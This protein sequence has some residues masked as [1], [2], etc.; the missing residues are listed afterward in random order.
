MSLRTASAIGLFWLLVGFAYMMSF[1]AD[2][3]R[4]GTKFKLSVG[5]V[6]LFETV[7]LS[8]A[9][10][11]FALHALLRGPITRRAFFP[12]ATIFIGGMLIWQPAIAVIDTTITSL[13]F[14][15]PLDTV[16]E[17]ALAIR[18]TMFFFNA[19][20]Y[21]VVFATCAGLILQRQSDEA[22]QITLALERKTRE[23]ELRLAKMHLRAL[24]N[25]LSPHFLFNSLGA[26]S[27]LARND[28]PEDVV[29]AVARLGD[30]L[31]YALQASASSMV[32]LKEEIDFTQSYVTPFEYQSPLSKA[33]LS[34]V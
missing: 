18:S 3:V 9:G 12:I 34:A 7:Y 8:W 22:K 13:V 4:F 23:A 20:L 31:R 26:I 11:T 30:M 15:K 16:I 25:Q 27:G 17:Q 32:T 21:V 19:V 2:A 28:A 29:R 6:I 24:Q 14:E 1:Y 5:M 33:R 10:L